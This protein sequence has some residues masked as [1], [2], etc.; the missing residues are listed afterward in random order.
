MDG[1][2]IEA[3]AGIPLR[4]VTVHQA[5]ADPGTGMPGEEPG[6][7]APAAAT[8]DAGPFAAD[9]ESSD[10]E[11]SL[12]SLRAGDSG[13]TFTGVAEPEPCADRLGGFDGDGE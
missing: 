1:N 10:F 5:G 12:A 11:K 9:G 2:G 13:Q 7:E 8:S 3:G 4:L 6:P